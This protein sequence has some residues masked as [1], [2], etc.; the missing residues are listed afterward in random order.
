MLRETLRL[1]ISMTCCDLV[2]L[3]VLDGDLALKA[4]VCTDGPRPLARVPQTAVSGH[5]RGVFLS[6]A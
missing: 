1:F 4:K 3:L 5:S 2:V 6:M